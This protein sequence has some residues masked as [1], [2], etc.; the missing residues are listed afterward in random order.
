[1]LEI[2]RTIREPRRDEMPSNS[3]ALHQ[4]ELK[5]SAKI[6][7]GYK[8][9][10]KEAVDSLPFKFYAEVNVN[11][12]R[13]WSL[14]LALLNELPDEVALIFG[15]YDNEPN[16]GKYGNKNELIHELENYTR[17]IA[18]DCHLEIGMIFHTDNELIEIFIAEA[19]YIKFW[20]INE[21]SFR[22]LMI[23]FGLHEIADIEFIDEYP[24]VVF[25]LKSI[26]KTVFD[27]YEVI[28]RLKEKYIEN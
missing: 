21:P 3:P 18:E 9:L 20:G 10:Y 27:S 24:K 25:P 22:K 17:E 14:L 7:E 1:M 13:L 19:K 6:V 8:L 4:L 11:N 26:D 5:K 28:Q 15:F 23:D 12:S 16:Y 2:P